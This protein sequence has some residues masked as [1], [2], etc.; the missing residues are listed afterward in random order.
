MAIKKS[1]KWDPKNL[2]Q[3][4]AVS[5]FKSQYNDSSNKIVRSKNTKNSQLN[6]YNDAAADNSTNAKICAGLC[7]SYMEAGGIPYESSF[8]DEGQDPRKLVF[9]KLSTHLRDGDGTVL[10]TADIVDHY[11]RFINEG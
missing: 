4:Y 3:R 6:Y 7:V 2:A 5:F 11:F 1:S 10:F 8:E 9:N